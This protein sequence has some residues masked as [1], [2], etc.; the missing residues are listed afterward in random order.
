[1]T[2]RIVN[3][4]LSLLLLVSS[5]AARPESE[6]PRTMWSELTFLR[7]GSD[8][9][10]FVD[11]ARER[12]M[13]A[14]QQRVDARELFAWALYRVVHADAAHDHVVVRQ[15]ID[16]T[17]L[18]EVDAAPAVLKA[19]IARGLYA[20]EDHQTEPAVTERPWLAVTWRDL[21]GPDANY[22]AAMEST[23]APV[24]KTWVAAG[25]PVGFSGYRVALPH[26]GLLGHDHAWVTL[27][28][29]FEDLLRHAS[30]N[31][32]FRRADVPADVALAAMESLA[33]TRGSEVWQLL[34]I[35]RRRPPPP[36]E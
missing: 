12:I 7:L 35:A 4:T 16:P 5:A 34:E 1:M 17:R 22:R 18:S 9:P 20:L 3:L 19:R 14:M 27:Y 30:L 23:W 6:I 29:S 10:A 24:L 32:A 31:D 28:A 26:S 2:H 33:P 15:A 36:S 8:A 13:P 11:M 21:T 25:A